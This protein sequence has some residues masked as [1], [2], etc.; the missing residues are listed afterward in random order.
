MNQGKYIF[1]Q[2]IG[3][4][5]HKQ[6]QTIVHRHFGDRKVKDFTCWKQFLCMVFGQLTHR[7][8]ISDTM[9]CLKANAGK[10]YH[11]GIG[12]V[13]A[14]STIT[15]ANENRSFKIYEDLA[16]LL[17]KEAKQLY[18][19][20]DGL[21]VALTGN[22]F[23]IDATTIDLCLSAFHWATFRTTKGGIKLHT[24]LD[25]KTA[26]P[27]F[28]LFSTASVNDMNVLDTIHFEANSFYVMDRGYVDYKRLYKVHTSNAFFVIRAK[29]N[30]NYRRLYSHPKDTA[31][32]ILFDQTIVF[33][34][35]YAARDYPQKLRCIKFEDRHTGRIFV[36][37]TNNF[38]LT[39]PQIAQLYKHRWKIELFFKWIKQHLKIKSFWGQ[40]E[41]AVKTQ[42]WI[43]VSVYVLVAIAKK[44]FALDQSLYEILQI[45]S[46]SI[47][48][49]MP[50]NQLF[51]QTQLQYFKEQNHNQLTIFD[52]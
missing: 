30:M 40:S 10:M 39:A 13:V 24:Q 25:L 31:A 23:A 1:S 15:R 52:L 33:G 9:L 47:F 22:V 41:N 5:S 12:E 8:S 49:K 42:V 16:M 46:I 21:E 4:I 34:N 48:E 32:G 38:H 43:A 6:F 20:D 50:I 11:L 2:I 26:I 18:L 19:L 44:R 51:G 17:I 27:E 29:D 37:L 36:F 35:H 28:I 14:V 45:L 7:Q 3:L